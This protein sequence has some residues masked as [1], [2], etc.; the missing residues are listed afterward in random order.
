MWRTLYSRDFCA[1]YFM[2]TSNSVLEL[3]SLEKV[4][5]RCHIDM[6]VARECLA[7]MADE[8]LMRS[9][10]WGPDEFNIERGD[11]EL[12]LK[13]MSIVHF[14]EQHSRRSI[15]PGGGGAPY[16]QETRRILRASG[17]FAL[18]PPARPKESFEG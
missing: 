13:E 15:R 10:E 9:H 3:L 8:D 1:P 17:V 2:G 14:V 18:V 7:R 11:I 12:L 5:R 4:A 6:S 16:E